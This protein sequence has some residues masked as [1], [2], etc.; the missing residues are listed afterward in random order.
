LI[1]TLP[2][3]EIDPILKVHDFLEVTLGARGFKRELGRF[4][5][6]GIDTKAALHAVH[7]ACQGP[8]NGK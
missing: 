4:Q 3:E 1:A 6:S 8:G 5:T 2:E 7:D